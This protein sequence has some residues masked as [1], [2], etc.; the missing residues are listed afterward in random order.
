M[1]TK[2]QMAWKKFPVLYHVDPTNC[3]HKDKL[4]V[5]NAIVN[6]FKTYNTA[7]GKEAFKQTT[8]RSYAKIKVFWAAHDGPL[9]QVAICNYNYM[10]T[11]EMTAATVKF[12]Q[13]DQWF[14]ATNPQCGYDGT[15]FDVQNTAAHELGHAI[16]LSHVYN[17]P[18]S[19]LF[20][21]VKRGETLRRTLDVGTLK[22]LK[23]LYPPVTV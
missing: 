14:I 10:L 13:N 18:V 4:A 2:P 7:I 15:A 16:G 19:S 12:D 17:D 23:V 6:A 22:A 11:G 8:D 1:L 5:T 9:G 3:N 21:T 20:P